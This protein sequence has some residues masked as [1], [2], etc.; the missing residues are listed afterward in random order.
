MLEGQGKSGKNLKK[1]REFTI[2][3]ELGLHLRPA[4]LF[5]KTV[6]N[7]QADITVEKDGMQADGK[8]IIGITTLNVVKN[9]KIIVEACGKDA[10]QALDALGRLIAGNFEET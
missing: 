10:D 7:Y 9:S 1:T 4:G 8:S 5:V 2:K 3:N 6:K